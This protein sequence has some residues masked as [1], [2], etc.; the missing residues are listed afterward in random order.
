VRNPELES[1]LLQMGFC[2]EDFD[3]IRRS[4]TYEEAVQKLDSLKTRF[5]SAF[6]KKVH[7]LHPDRTSGDSKKTAQLQL[8]LDFSKEL[9]AT[10]VP[11]GVAPRIV[12]HRVIFHNPTPQ[13]RRAGAWSG[14]PPEIR[15]QVTSVG[16]ASTVAGMRPSGV[17][18]N[19][20]R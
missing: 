14:L 8:L 6:R 9:E 7:E 12:I 17:V 15:T 1:L 10:Q 5:K 18:G 20:G 16:T 2:P 11:R 3:S 19:R 4:R 13:T